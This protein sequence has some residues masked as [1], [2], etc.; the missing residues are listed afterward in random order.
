MKDLETYFALSL[1]HVDVA[2]STDT[3]TSTLDVIRMPR[4]N[5]DEKVM[6]NAFEFDALGASISIALPVLYLDEHGVGSN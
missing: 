4:G 1:R 2:V 5:V 3:A 6:T